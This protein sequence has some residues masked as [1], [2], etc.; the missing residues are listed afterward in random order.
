MDYLYLQ[1][2]E[3]GRRYALVLKDDLCGY[4]WLTPVLKETAAHT[5][6][7]LEKSGT[8]LTPFAVR[9]TGNGAH[10]MDK[11][12]LHSLQDR[13]YA[14]HRRYRTHIVRIVQKKD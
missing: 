8:I 7:A 2:G 6:D 11:Y 3:N 1:D 5:A 10:F 12:S 14:T 4:Y 13:V 9:I